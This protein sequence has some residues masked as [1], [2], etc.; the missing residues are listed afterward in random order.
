MI[1]HSA[2][3]DEMNEDL[4]TNYEKGLSDAIANYRLKEFNENFSSSVSVTPFI[5][6]FAFLA[7]QPMVILLIVSAVLFYFVE[8][9]MPSTITPFVNTTLWV[10]VYIVALLMLKSLIGYS[11]EW[12][13]AHEQKIT[14]PKATVIRGGVEKTI[15]SLDVVPGDLIILK[16][17]KSVPADARLIKSE[18][19]TCNESAVTGVQAPVVKD[20]E[21]VCS[22]ITP[23]SQRANMVYS[24]SWVSHGYGVAVVTETGDNTEFGKRIAISRE[25]A[26]SDVESSFSSLKKLMSQISFFVFIFVLICCMLVTKFSANGGSYT[27]LTVA[28]YVLFVSSA[29]SILFSPVSISDTATVNTVISL[30]KLKK[31]NIS[32]TNISVIDE[33]GD[34]NCICVDKSAVTAHNMVATEIYNGLDILD[35]TG[36]VSSDTAMLLRLAA[37][38][39][40][41]DGDSTDSA[42]I[43]ACKNLAMMDKKEVDNLYPLLSYVPFDDEYMT[44]VSV[45]MIDGQPY[46]IVKGAAESVAKFCVGDTEHIIK[47]AEAMGTKAL[48]V[49]AVAVKVLSSVSDTVSPSKDDLYGGLT[50][51]G[52]VGFADPIRNE[53]RNSVSECLDSGIQVKMFTGDS[54]FTAKAIARQAGILNDDNQAILGCELEELND[55]EFLDAVVNHTTFA[56]V[57]PSL[58]IKI[59]QTLKNAGYVIAATGRSSTINAAMDTANIGC[60]LGE[61]GSDAV[62]RTAD[63]VLNDDSFNSIVSMIKGGRSIYENMRRSVGAVLTVNIALVLIELFGYFIWQQSVLNPLQIVT[64]CLLTNIFTIFAIAFEP[65]DAL[66]NTKRA[67]NDTGLNA[68][69]RI[70][71]IWHSAVIAIVSL[72]AYALTHS[73]TSL[74]CLSTFICGSVAAILGFKSKY[75]VIGHNILNNKFSLF[76]SSGAFLLVYVF[77]CLIA[78]GSFNKYL[79]LLIFLS[80][81]PLVAIEAGKIIVNYKRSK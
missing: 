19:L 76:L 5:N 24:G 75:S 8:A 28:S 51:L 45:N 44:T 14:A 63:V 38:A 10:I 69:Q 1:W 72:I 77:S 78:G 33:M 42:L 2:T 58:R 23:L 22:D 4:Q 39:S 31:K 32:V 52:L 48:H 43:T 57:L 13:M 64:A 71:V 46:A 37:A 59:I 61:S 80:L 6:R 16:P 36:G 56:R 81:L 79:V 15:S 3:L 54:I 70:N 9:L 49:I 73:V 11:C 21:F 27:W 40:L 26:L 34:V 67:S 29:V 12:F 7:K 74:A 47:S 30:L 20:C 18:T 55:E 50:F 65:F 62:K 25:S 66:K 68:D 17:R 60:A 53:V 35:I 41:E